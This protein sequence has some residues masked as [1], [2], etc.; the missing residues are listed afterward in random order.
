MNAA[1]RRHREGRGVLHGG[2]DRPGSSRSSW[3]S[4]RWSAL[5]AGYMT[6]Q[7]RRRSEMLF[8]RHRRRSGHRD[9]RRG[10]GRGDVR[11]RPAAVDARCSCWSTTGPAMLAGAWIR[12]QARLALASAPAAPPRPAR[13]RTPAG[14][15]VRL[16]YQGEPGAYS[17]AAAR[18]LRRP[19]AETLPCKSFDDVFE[20]VAEAAGHARRAAARELDRRHHPPQLRPAGRARPVRSP[21]KWSSTSSTA[22]RRCPAPRSPT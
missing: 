18:D 2:L 21:A 22:C 20:A 6:A 1:G 10:A 13:A 7:D 9:A 5:L 11:R 15:L 8:G 17:E 3:R 16:A 19:G 14:R 4:T 12:M